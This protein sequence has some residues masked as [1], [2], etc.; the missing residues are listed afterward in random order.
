L[1]VLLFPLYALGNPW[2]N[3]YTFQTTN[4]GDGDLGPLTFSFDLAPSPATPF[5]LVRENWVEIVPDLHLVE[6]HLDAGTDRLVNIIPDPNVPQEIWGTDLAWDA[7]MTASLVANSTYVYFGS[8]GT[9]MPMTDVFGLGMVFSPHPL[10]AGIQVLSWDNAAGPG[11]L[12]FTTGQYATN[13][14]GLLSALG[15]PSSNVNQITF[16]SFVETSTAQQ[17]PEPTA[18]IMLAAGLVALG[19]LGRKSSV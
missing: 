11:V 13:L 7:G 8:R 15:V 9:P 2:G 18:G 16:G 1:S 5:D 19:L 4:F 12:H 14:S 17:T 6:M 10:D 3:P